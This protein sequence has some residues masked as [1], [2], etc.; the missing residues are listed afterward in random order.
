M[1]E[2]R[3]VC[4]FSHAVL[5]STGFSHSFGDRTE[6]QTCFGINVTMS[7]ENV[8]TPPRHKLSAAEVKIIK[9]TWKIPSA[10]V[11]DRDFVLRS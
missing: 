3:L 1:S 7:L 4:R 11:G 8:P 10:N 5:A 9:E 6:D 2:T